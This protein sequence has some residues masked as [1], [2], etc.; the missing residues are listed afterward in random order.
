MATLDQLYGALLKADAVGDTE[1]ARILAQY[2]QQVRGGMPQAAPTST[3]PKEDTGFFDMAGRAVVRGAKQTGSL[4]GDVLPAMIGRAVGADEY[5]ARQM[6][7]AEET[8]KEIEAKYGA[9]YKELSDVKGLGDVLPFIAETAL[10]QIP[11][12]A[13]AIIP[14]VGGAVTGGRMAAAQAAAKVKARQEAGET[15]AEEAAKRYG[16]IAA[17]KGAERGGL[18]GAFLGSYALNAPEVFQNIYESTKDEFTGEGQMELGASLLAG[19]VSAALDSILPAYLVRQFTPGMKMGVVERILEKSGM[20]TGVARGAT[21]GVITGAVTEAPTE[22]AQEAISIAAEKFVNENADVWGS[23]DF[24]R[25]VESF[26]RGG[27]GG[28]AITGVAGGVKGYMDRPRAPAK[29]TGVPGDN[30]ITQIDKGEVEGEAPPP[31]PEGFFDEE[32]ETSALQQIDAQERRKKTRG[33]PPPKLSPEVKELRGQIAA[34]NGEIRRLEEAGTDETMMAAW[35]AERERL[36]AQERAL[37]RSEEGIVARAA[38]IEKTTPQGLAFTPI[39]PL[40][41]F[42]DLPTESLK[43]EG[44]GVSAQLTRDTK[45]E[46]NVWKVS[47][48]RAETPGKGQGTQFGQALTDWADQNGATLQLVA[49]ANKVDKQQGLVN[50]Y[51]SLGFEPTAESKERADMGLSY[52][53]LIRY[54]KT[55]SESSTVLRASSARDEALRMAGLSEEDIQDRREKFGEPGVSYKVTPDESRITVTNLVDAG[56]YGTEAEN[57]VNEIKKGRVSGK[58]KY[59]LSK[60]SSGMVEFPDG[61]RVPTDQDYQS[62]NDFTKAKF[63]RAKQLG[64]GASQ[65]SLFR[66]QQIGL[67]LAP[68]TEETQREFISPIAESER[69]FALTA[70][71]GTAPREVQ[72]ETEEAPAAAPMNLVDEYNI[73]R[74]ED[75]FNNL[76]PTVEATSGIK[77]YKSAIKNFIDEINEYL[78]GSRNQRVENLKIINSFFNSLGTTSDPQQAANLARDLKG[79]TTEQQAEILRNR[80]KMP[81]ITTPTGLGELRK[82]FQD[83]MEQQS[84]A[85]VGT[86]PAAA[87]T[88]TFG[89]DIFVPAEVA[90]ILRMLRQKPAKSLSPEEKAFM[91]Y[92]SKFKYGLAMRSAAYDLAENVPMGTMFSGQGAKNAALF[93]KFVDKNFPPLIAD[94]FNGA[95]DEYKN[96]SKYLAE[97]FEKLKQARTRRQEYMRKEKTERKETVEE[98][99]KEEAEKKAKEQTDLKAKYAKEIKALEEAKK[100]EG[101]FKTFFKAGTPASNFKP[102]HPAVEDKISNN[103]VDGA[104]ELIENFPDSMYW[105][106]LAKRLRAANITASIRFDEQERLMRYEV[107]KIKLTVDALLNNIYATYPEV[108]NLYIAPAINEVGE[109]DIRRFAEGLKTIKNNKLIS[110]KG[111]KSRVFERTFDV[112]TDAVSSLDAPGFYMADNKMEAINLNRSANGNSYYAFFHELIHAATSLAI[113]NPSRLNPA[114]KEALKNL[115]ALYKEATATYPAVSVYGFQNLDEF[116]AE[117]FSNVEFQRLLSSIPYKTTESSLWSKFIQYVRRL[118]GGKDTALF[119]TLANADI[120]M[121]ATQVRGSDLNKYSGT[122]KATAIPTTNYKTAPDVKLSQAWLDILPDRLEWNAAKEGVGRLLENV[123]DTTRKYFLGAFT[124]RQLQDLIGTRL[125]GTA[126]GFINTI[127][128]M[129]EDHNRII[130]E[131]K[132][133]TDLWT[134]L[135]PT[136]NDNVST[137]MLDSTLRFIDPATQPG[138]DFDLDQRWNALSDDAKTVYRKVRD[139]YEQRII[140]YKQTL[141]DNIEMSLVSKN[142]PAQEIK[143]KL[144][145]ISQEFDKDSIKPYFP[146]RRFGP[147]WLQVGEGKTKEFMMFDSAAARNAARRMVEEEINTGKRK[148]QTIYEGNSLR[149]IRLQNLQ[150]IDTLQRIEAIVDEAAVDDPIMKST[151]VGFDKKIDYLREAIKDS[152]EELYL[153]TL[154]SKSIRKNFITRKGIAGA[155]KDMLR[156]FSETSSR[157]AYQHARFKHS[158]TMFEQL[159]AAREIQKSNTKEG[160]PNTKVDLDYINE[161]EK[162]LEY[163]MNPSNTGTLPTIL[164]NVSFIWYLTAPASA[165]VNMLGVPAIGFPVLAARFGKGKSAATLASYGKRFISAGFKD[166]NGKFSMPSLSTTNLSLEERAAYDIFTASGLIDITQAYDLAGLAESPSNMYTGKMSTIMRWSSYMFHHAERFNREVVAMSAF[167]MAYDKAK[168]AG[169]PNRVAFQKAINE[170]KDLTYRSMFDYSTLNKPRY[171]QNAYAK[172]I[173]QFKQFPQHMTFLLAHSAFLWFSPQNAELKAEVRESIVTERLQ[174]GLPPLTDEAK[175]NKMVDEEV[176]RIAKEGRDRVLGT[177]GMTFLFA[178]ATGLPLF[179]VGATVIEAV[180]AAFSD[181][182]EPPLDFENWFKNWMATT[183]GNFWGDSISRGVITQATGMNFA[184]R[185][186]LNDLWFRDARK[187]QDEVTAFQNMIINL[188]G[189]TASLAVSG[190]EALKLYNDG[191]YYRGAEKALPAFLKQPLVGARYATEGALTLKGDELVSGSELSAKDA[192]AQSLGFAPEKVS[193]RQKANIEMKTAEQEILTKRQDLYNAF[194]MGVDTSNDDL[195]DRV[196]EKIAKFNRMYPGRAITAEGLQKSIKNRYKARAL[197]EITGGIPIDKKLMADLMEMGYYGDLD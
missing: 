174:L 147:Y 117:A 180:H 96:R 163:V 189:P 39:K 91:A 73:N 149:D 47:G 89:S 177:L 110:E 102:L 17:R 26:V 68:A 191:H 14:G 44:F 171:L 134:N 78:G 72:I 41:E 12:L 70:P 144:A 83:F 32:Y 148:R 13:T 93:K 88:R 172:V 65:A 59:I 184:D 95:V 135:T 112:Y 28:G 49:A 164:S 181:D 115:E 77:N 58:T 3:P 119:G 50:F 152:V 130:N 8:Q 114:Q 6:A 85:K 187:S 194:F 192:L 81:N 183:F 22:A 159:G 100:G 179:S 99:A 133:I 145:A 54:P 10:E 33:A 4:L 161:L 160:K 166:A 118:L 124:L 122:L 128:N 48:V 156:A 90:N 157:M 61:W 87:A 155:S 5:A 139:F 173:L 92:M 46:P 35:Y 136:E 129:L 142:T 108:F 79:K 123:T 1:A 127:E 195:I 24:N 45:R 153:M 178:G 57:I 30:A 51:E 40:S 143:E 141:L 21:A 105:K 186:S 7:E 34:L 113:K 74:L 23:K 197:A 109:I 52:S 29:E 103:D 9:R 82:Q 167:R 190:V 176:K 16:A 20:P 158:R 37:R 126:S 84:L 170:A 86:F 150:D 56:V 64:A 27:V 94:A 60:V 71:E 11:N 185:M 66:A 38:S 188:L 76:Q 53:S 111:I 2:I 137:L 140:E 106:L 25:L 98:F 75:M 43:V 62:A 97:Q 175:L 42:K 162:R 146:I 107:S 63:D 120:L 125:G 101:L 121:S 138:K 31:P 168:T 196:L 15:V 55:P 104:L 67:D 19:S 193:Q 165:L 132:D 36:Q 169:L 116:I 80:T 69:E 151:Y 154:P 18:S 182:D 131:A